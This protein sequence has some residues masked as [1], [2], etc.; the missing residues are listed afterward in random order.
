DIKAIDVLISL[1][2]DKSS[3]IRNWATFGIGDLTTRDSKKIRE[4]LWKRINDRHAETSSEAIIGL[5]KRKDDRI[6]ELILKR[7]SKGNYPSLLF[8]AITELNDK[9]FLP[10]LKEH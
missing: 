1:S 10:I 7:L 9:D 6:K 5:A 8:E 4:A 3:E 2:S